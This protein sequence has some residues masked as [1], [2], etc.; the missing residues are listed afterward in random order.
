MIKLEKGNAPAELTDDFVKE[1]TEIYKNTK[2]SVWNV[3][4]LKEALL[5]LSNNKCA[6]CEGNLDLRSDYVEVEHFRDKKDFPDEVLIWENLLPSCKHCNGHKSTH[7]VVT[8]PIIN[9]FNEDP[10]NHI[11]LRSYMYKSKDSLGKSTIEVLDLNDTSRLVIA[12]CKIGTEINKLLCEYLEE[13][14]NGLTARG[15]KTRFKNKF[16]GLLKK[17][18]PAAEYSAVCSTELVTSKE[19]AE[20]IEDMKAQELWDAEFEKYHN[21]VT[22]IAL[23]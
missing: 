20:I 23:I 17:C 12:R 10:K 3:D 18:L 22:S 4:W 5:K 21:I 1:Q 11:Y 14:N 6:Y 13:I 8:E 19:Y 7:N 2:K 9:P 15:S 16:R